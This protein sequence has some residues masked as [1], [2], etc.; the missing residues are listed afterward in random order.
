M[1]FKGWL[2]DREREAVLYAVGVCRTLSPQEK[3][4]L[5]E[6]LCHRE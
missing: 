4:W 5:T 3:I 1:N 2:T 6:A